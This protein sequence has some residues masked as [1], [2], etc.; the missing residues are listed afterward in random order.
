MPLVV[1]SVTTITCDGTAEA[2]CPD[3]AAVVHEFPQQVSIRLA[4]KTGWL[5]GTDFLCPDC[6]LSSTHTV[7]ISEWPSASRLPE[8]PVVRGL[9][10][11]VLHG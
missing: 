11:A 9:K 7:P 6:A 10:V 1:I 3:S 8:V 2:P 5:I 4:R